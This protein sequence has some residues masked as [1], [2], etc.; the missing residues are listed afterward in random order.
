MDKRWAIAVLLMIL[1]AAGTLSAQDNTTELE[2]FRV[3]LTSG[4]RI[5]GRDGSLTSDGLQG[6]SAKGDLVFV[7]R[8]DI[9]LLDRYLG[10]NGGKGAKI[11]AAIG[12]GTAILSYIMA[13]SEAASDPYKEVDNSRIAPIFIG[14]A[15]VGALIGYAIG[16]SQTKWEKVPYG[17]GL[18]FDLRSGEARLVLTL[19]L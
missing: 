2:R 15:G 10:N 5:E 18:G 14:F 12:L 11:G 16:S 4:E 6:V 8:S 9:R 7:A 13:R 1:M 3:L 19:S 17:T